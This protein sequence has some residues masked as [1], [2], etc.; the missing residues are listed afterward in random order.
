CFK[1]RRS[2][3]ATST[4]I[5]VWLALACLSMLLTAPSAPAQCGANTLGYGNLGIVKDNP[6]HAE[7]VITFT[8]QNPL[9]DSLL[10][11]PEFVA[12]DSQGRIRI[13]RVVGEYKHDTG[14]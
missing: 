8:R 6:F 9:A 12:R 1:L 3:L 7:V 10:R 14:A 13:E 4:V 11:K 2:P 5:P